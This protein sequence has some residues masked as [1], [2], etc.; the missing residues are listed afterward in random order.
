[1]TE[2]I[3]KAQSILMVEDSEEDYE[4]T[5]RAFRRASLR[6]T[7]FWCKSGEEAIDFLRAKGNYVARSAAE[8]PGMILL[9]LNMRGMDGRKVL[10]I[11]KNDEE[12]KGIPVIILTTSGSD[13]DVKACYEAGANT[14]IQKP[15]TFE[16][17][18]DAMRRLKEFWFEIALL[19]RNGTG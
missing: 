10:E 4:A 6:N 19:P 16:G 1:M 5:L 3:S 14:Y 12:F 11:V 2:M 15:V 9:D 17:L 8:K 7:V 13:R 18:I